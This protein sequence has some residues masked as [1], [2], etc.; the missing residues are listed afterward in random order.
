MPLVSVSIK[1]ADEAK[2]NWDGKYRTLTST[3]N[4]KWEGGF[5]AA[6]G[7]H[8]YFV[9]VAGQPGDPWTS[10][11][12]DGTSTDDVNGKMKKDGHGN[13]GTRDFSVA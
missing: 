8:E 12:T 5:N 3:G 13:S 11:V 9:E 2:F 1:G 4:G 10:E 6:S 7:G